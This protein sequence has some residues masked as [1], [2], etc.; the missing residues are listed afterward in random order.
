MDENE[1][2][3]LPASAADDEPALIIPEAA[4]LRNPI[5][6]KDMLTPAEAVDAIALLAT[7]LKCDDVYRAQLE[8]RKVPDGD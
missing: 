2:V 6:G 7:M 4:Y 8:A 5:A 1:R 3:D